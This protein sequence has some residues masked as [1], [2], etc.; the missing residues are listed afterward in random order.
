MPWGYFWLVLAALSWYFFTPALTDMQHFS[1]QWMLAI[2]L[3]NAGILIL[4]AGGLHWWYYIH[5]GQENDTKFTQK[6]LAKDDDK[7]LWRDQVKDNMFWSLISGVTIWS[8]YEVMTFWWYANGFVTYKS[9]SEAPLYF[10]LSIWGVMFWSTIHFYLNHRLLHWGPLFDISHELHHRNANTG[11][12]TGISMHPIE[13]VIYFSV[14]LIW[15]IIPVHP[16]IIL[17]TGVFQGVAPSVSHSG[18][19]YLKL[20]KNF[21]I[22]TGDNFHNLHHRFFHVNYG[23]VASPL[24][25]LFQSWHGGDAAGKAVLKRRMRSRSLVTD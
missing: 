11:P 21:R 16:V 8:A 3:R 23:N 10:I 20:G 4:V 13:H 12:W 1:W 18:F 17:L 15:W 14:F 6:W 24:D 9:I 7:F 19:D 2:W 25:K 22:S 5:K